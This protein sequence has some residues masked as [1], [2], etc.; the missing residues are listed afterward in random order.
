MCVQYMVTEDKDSEG[1]G[2]L[3]TSLLSEG[4]VFVH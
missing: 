1:G 3:I 4:L 2:F